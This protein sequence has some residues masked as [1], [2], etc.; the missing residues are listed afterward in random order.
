MNE[1]VLCEAIIS[2]STEAINELINTNVANGISE[3]VGNDIVITTVTT[4]IGIIAGAACSIKSRFW[5][6]FTFILSAVVFN[7]FMLLRM[8]FISEP[9]HYFIFS[10][11]VW[12]VLCLLGIKLLREKEIVSRKKIGKMIEAFTSTA[13]PSKDVCIFAGDI[14]F[15]GDVI[16]NSEYAKS[17]E[18]EKK[19]FPFN[20]I[21]AMKQKR[22]ERLLN[23]V[24]IENNSQFKQLKDSKFRSVCILCV[25]PPPQ[26]GEIKDDY[27][28][29]RIRIGYIKKIFGERVHFKFFNDDCDNCFFY[30]QNNCMLQN[31]THQ[32]T[33]DPQFSCACPKSNNAFSH[34]SLPDTTLRGRIVTNRETD[35]KCVAITTKRSS[36]KDYILRQY[37]SGEKESSLYN[38]IWKVW[39]KMCEEDNIF[40]DEC[41]REYNE[42]EKADAGVN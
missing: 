30:E 19:H 42:S 22:K 36:R 28:K 20:L 25:K 4:V 37:G 14:D 32:C 12:T 2:T 16:E 5:R 35:A 39:W 8:V 18:T 7:A 24:N 31:C 21:D 10:L 15:F 9:L 41:V 38:V 26:K 11:I 13:N 23:K 34:P 17:K 40:I 6:N 27:H 1:T 3:F 29:D 33:A